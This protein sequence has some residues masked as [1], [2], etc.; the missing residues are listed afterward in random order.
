MREES[1][2]RPDGFSARSGRADH[3]FYKPGF[4]LLENVIPD[5]NLIRWPMSLSSPHILP[6]SF[7]QK[8]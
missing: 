4:A 5:W 7:D 2:T 3:F 8:G 6:F 1:S